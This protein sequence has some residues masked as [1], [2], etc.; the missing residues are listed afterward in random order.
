MSLIVFNLSGDD[1]FL[2]P[3]NHFP[4]SQNHPQ[5]GEKMLLIIITT[6]ILYLILIAWTWKNLGYIE[7]TKKV[8]FIL[9]GTILIYGI[10][11]I[12]FQI[13]K[14]GINYQNATMQND[15]QNMLVAI[16]TGINGMILMPQ[17]GKILDK[18]KEDEIK[19]EQLIKRISVL[20]IVFILCLIFESGYMRD[21]QEGILKVYHTMK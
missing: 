15:V 13:A 8:A 1:F 5:K 10:T 6:I 21:T 2:R 9:I 20:T 3:Q 18:I 4:P 11:W 14:N 16:F 12:I 17:I 7:K 19:K